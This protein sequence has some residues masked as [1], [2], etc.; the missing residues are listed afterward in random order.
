MFKETK[1]GTH[2]ATVVGV[3]KEE[4]QHDSVETGTKN[5]ERGSKTPIHQQDTS[6]TTRQV[7]ASGRSP[8][9]RLCPSSRMALYE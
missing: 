4:K 7:D 8:D 2:K 9:T 1:I 3:R 5:E 6:T